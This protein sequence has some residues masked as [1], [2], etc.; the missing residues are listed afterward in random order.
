MQLDKFG[1]NKCFVLFSFYCPLI[2]HLG[3]EP[4]DFRVLSSLP[5]E[6]TFLRVLPKVTYGDYTGPLVP[7]LAPEYTIEGRSPDLK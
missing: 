2:L 6:P 5:I 7:V 4:W 3:K 1:L